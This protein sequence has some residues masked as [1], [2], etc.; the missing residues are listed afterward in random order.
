MTGSAW[1]ANASNTENTENTDNDDISNLEAIERDLKS[2][3]DTEVTKSIQQAIELAVMAGKGK[4][5]RSNM[6]AVGIAASAASAALITFA[7]VISALR[8]KDGKITTDD[9]SG[10]AAYSIPYAT[11]ILTKKDERKAPSEMV[12]LSDIVE[13]TLKKILPPQVFDLR[14]D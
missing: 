8:R 11:F 6:M 9:I 13:K 14:N 3:V 10:A 7:T 1:V 2:K 5:I 12:E 4:G